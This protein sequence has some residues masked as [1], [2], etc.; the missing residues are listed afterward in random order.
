[1][2]IQQEINP[3]DKSDLNTTMYLRDIEVYLTHESNNVNN[4]SAT[5]RCME[6]LF[7]RKI[8]KISTGNISKVNIYLGDEYDVYIIKQEVSNIVDI[9]SPFD[10]NQFSKLHAN[11]DKKKY[12]AKCIFES[13][14]RLSNDK[15]WDSETFINAFQEI[16]KNNYENI[17][18]YKNKKYWSN[19]RKY[20]VQ[21]LINFDVNLY[22]IKINLFDNKKGLIG[23]RVIFKHEQKKFNI[24]KV[25]WENKYIFCIKFIG[26]QKIFKNSIQD[27]IDKTPFLLPEKLSDWFKD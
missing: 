10:F 7:L 17:V 15:I 24:E 12:M 8:D 2:L 21:I 14:L 27:I 26:P 5:A 3:Q 25:Y 9:Y 4:L 13:L 22:E 23:E 19:D 18:T 1:M 16:I 6:D 11:I 20:F